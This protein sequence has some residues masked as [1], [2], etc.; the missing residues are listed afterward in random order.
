MAISKKFDNCSNQKLI[1]YFKKSAILTN[2]SGFDCLET[3]YGS[4]LFTSD[5]FSNLNKNDNYGG[6]YKTDLGY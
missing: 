5:F 1:E 2:K 6:N 4:W 3:S